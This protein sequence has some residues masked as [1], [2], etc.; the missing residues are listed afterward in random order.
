MWA[1]IEIDLFVF[2]TLY[3][4]LGCDRIKKKRPYFQQKALFLRNK[5]ATVP[6]SVLEIKRFSRKIFNFIKL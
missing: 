3:F 5:S 6:D 2:K 4:A 1:G